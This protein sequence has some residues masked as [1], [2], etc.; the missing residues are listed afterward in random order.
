MIAKVITKGTSREETITKM[1]K[2]LL[3][4]KIEGIKTNIP[5]L[6]EV[7]DNDQFQKGNYSTNLVKTMRENT[8][9]N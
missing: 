4:T 8:L 1:R 6:L 2:A 9:K 5:L 3:E 7:L